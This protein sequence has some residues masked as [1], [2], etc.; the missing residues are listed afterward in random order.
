MRRLLSYFTS[1]VLVLPAM[2]EDVRIVSLGGAVTETVF[3][4]GAGDQVVARDDT[5]VRPAAVHALPSVGYVRTI[6]AEGILAMAPTLVLASAALGPPEQVTILESSGIDFIQFDE[7]PSAESVLTLV[8]G[9]G[10]ALGREAAA[11]VLRAELAD[12]FAAIRALAEAHE[13][14]PTVVVLMGGGSGNSYSAA[15]DGTAATALIELAGGRNPFTGVPGYKPT[16]AEQILAEE[17]DF[18]FLTTRV[19]QR[20]GLPPVG[21][22]LPGNPLALTRAGQEGR[23]YWL[24]MGTYL[25]FGPHIAEAGHELAILLHGGDSAV[26]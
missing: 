6:G 15:Y 26:D 24:D 1:L 13:S 7:K 16:S 3:A 18:I 22:L 12:K 11:D 20:E 10:E 8:D 9:V 4:L 17:P 23:V 19:P 21:D 25:L 2:A 5:S 14:P